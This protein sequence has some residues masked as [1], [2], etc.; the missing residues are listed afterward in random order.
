[1][2]NPTPGDGGEDT[3]NVSSNVPGTAFTATAHY[4][5][6]DHTFSSATDGSGAG[7]ITFSIGRPTVGYRVV[8]DV[9]ISGRAQCQTSFTPQ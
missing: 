9:N 3:V 2:S 1:M 6:T 5:T 7:S 8:V 4:R